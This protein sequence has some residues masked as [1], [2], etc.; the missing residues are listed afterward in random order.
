MKKSRVKRG[1][2][3]AS[4]V[5]GGLAVLVLAFF[6]GF[7]T[8]GAF[9]ATSYDWALNIIN[10]YYYTEVDT[11][12]AQEVAID[13]LVEEY[14]DIY[15]EYYT[16]EEY[17]ALLQSNAGKASGIGISYAFIEGEGAYIVYAVGNSPAYNAGV[18]SGDVIVSGKT[19]G[20]SVEFETSSDFTVFMND[21]SLGQEVTFVTSEDKS[22]T[23]VAGEYTISYVNFATNG[24]GWYFSGDDALTL[25]ESEGDA[26]KYLPDG[27]GYIALYRFYGDAAAQMKMAVQKLNE[28]G[29]ETVILDLRNNGGG[30]VSVM[31]AILGCFESC[32]G[33]EVMTAVYKSGSASKTTASSYSA[34]YTLD[35]DVRLCVL[36]NGNTASASEALIGA[37]IS[38]GALDYADVCIS[39]YSEGYLASVGRTADSA[40]SGRTYGKGIMQ[41]TYVNPLTGE[42]LKLTT[43][44]LYWPNGKTIHGTGLSESDGCTIVSAPLP[45]SGKGVELY[46]A[47]QALFY[48]G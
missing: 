40:K 38:Y 48:S 42:A 46:G 37:L 39:E 26:I 21:L 23:F 2:I 5:V 24:G 25:T 41:T 45:A 28:L 13:A 30:S 19:D 6:G 27:V 11:S 10:T 17:A 47:V 9:G 34:E 4:S 16:A 18:R 1:I 36:A 20:E 35:S 43:A 14:L 22:C 44:Q 8:R 15:S 29:C 32:A 7:W 12:N 3:I 31:S 33:Q